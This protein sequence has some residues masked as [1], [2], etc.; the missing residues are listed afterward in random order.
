MREAI[1]SRCANFLAMCDCHLFATPGNPYRRLLDWA[2]YSRQR[3]ADALNRQGLEATLVEL[4]ASG[5]FL[6]ID[7]FKGKKPVI[8]KGLRLTV[9]ASAFDRAE[10]PSV[11]IRSSGSRGT[12]M[13][14]RIGIQGLRHLATCIPPML[15][16]LEA[17]HLPVVLYYPMPSVAGIVHLIIYSLGGRPPAAWFTQLEA[18]GWWRNGLGVKLAAILFFARLQGVHLP[19]PRFADIHRPL[20]MVAWLKQNCPEGAVVSTFTGS[21]M[22]LAQAAESAHILLPPLT[23]IVGGEPR[24]SSDAT[25]AAW[26]A[27]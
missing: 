19:A 21:A 4:A 22:H 26:S 23:F 16:Y 8:R 6:D 24:T 20:V 12:G 2:G 14:T 3:L 1:V 10:A 13:E 27:S 11:T 9:D 15:S 5:V 25:A 7:E 18:A 17:D